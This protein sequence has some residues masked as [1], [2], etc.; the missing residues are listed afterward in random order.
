VAAGF[1][2][3]AAAFPFHFW[4]AETYA[5]APASFVGFLSTVPKAVAIYAFFK[6]LGHFGPAA[7]IHPEFVWWLVGVV[8]TGSMVVGN[9]AAL[10]QRS[11]KRMLAFSSIAHAGFMLLAFSYLTAAPSGSLF[12]YAV[13]YTLLNMAAFQLAEIGER[14]TQ[15]EGFGSFAGWGKQK[16]IWGAAVLIVMLGLTGLPPTAGFTAKLLVF[17]EVW[18]AYQAHSSGLFLFLL[19]F[20]VL[21]AAI[22]LYYYLQIPYQLFLKEGI[23]PTSQAFRPTAVAF[24]IVLAV[25][26][27]ALFFIP[28]WLL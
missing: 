22:S 21:N 26:V 19:V 27:L 24:T 23:L 12:Y 9:L 4:I 14:L 16:P 15:K 2:F 25:L 18:Q 11:V 8:A 13:A 6:L 10:R 3:K 1:L 17:S 28:G 7:F 20:G 5:N